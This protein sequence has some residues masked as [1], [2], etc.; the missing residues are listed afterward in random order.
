ML[1]QPIWSC[2]L[3]K[4]FPHSHHSQPRLLRHGEV[5][6]LLLCRGVLVPPCDPAPAWASLIEI[7]L[8]ICWFSPA[9]QSVSLHFKSKSLHKHEGHMEI[10]KCGCKQRGRE[11][12]GI[13]VLGNPWLQST[14]YLP[15]LLDAVSSPVPQNLSA[16]QWPLK[17]PGVN[18]LSFRKAYW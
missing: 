9:L 13:F 16:A 12:K 10:L 17:T 5:Q 14:V 7:S 8:H 2:N 11:V 6:H 3:P 18:Y 4:R 1:K 15:A